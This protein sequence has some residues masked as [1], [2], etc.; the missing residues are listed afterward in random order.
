MAQAYSYVADPYV[1]A[2][3]WTGANTSDFA[4][5]G[6]TTDNVAIA[7]DGT[8]LILGALTAGFSSAQYN[9]VPLN[10]WVVSVQQTDVRTTPPTPLWELVVSVVDPDTFAAT[11]TPA[12]PVV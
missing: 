5:A 8:T 2:V 6:F 10:F 12:P 9:A 3:Q 1:I 4:D 7:E 11:F